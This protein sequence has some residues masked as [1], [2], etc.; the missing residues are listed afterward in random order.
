VFPNWFTNQ[1]WGIRYLYVTWGDNTGTFRYDFAGN[2]DTVIY[3]IYDFDVDGSVYQIRMSAEDY[4]GQR[5]PEVSRN[6]TLKQG[7]ETA[8]DL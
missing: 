4:L 8:G 7:S 1:S 6:V 5:S 3:H 2:A